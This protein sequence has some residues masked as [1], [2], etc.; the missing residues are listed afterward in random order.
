M[1]FR[2]HDDLFHSFRLTGMIR[3][4]DFISL[5]FPRICCGCGNTLWK[6]EE[7]ICRLC[8]FHL[9][10]THFHTYRDNPVARIFY[11]RVPIGEAMA[12][13]YFHKGNTVQRL[14][15]QLK[16]K[17][18][19][20]IGIFLGRMY[21][22]ELTGSAFPTPPDLIVPVPLHRKKYMKRGYNQSEQFAVGLS[23]ALHIPLNR[24]LLTRS[25]YTETQTRKNR[26]RR[27]QNVRNIFQVDQIGRASCR[28]RV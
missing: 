10:K 17:G 13:L 15:H 25:R 11:G 5:V 9:P 16:Y 24:R 7:V 19:K 3:L 14:I 4:S 23:E 26:F 22:A 18:R 27:W 12:F 28:E 8:E 20:D 6:H 21:G 1:L 2:S